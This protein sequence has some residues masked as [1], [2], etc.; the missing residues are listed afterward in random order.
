MTSQRR[1]F[2]R[3][4]GSVTAIRTSATSSAMEPKNQTNLAASERKQADRDRQHG[5]CREV[6]EDEVPV[7]LAVERFGLGGSRGRLPVDLEVRHLGRRLVD[8]HPQ[9]E[10][11]EEAHKC[12]PDAGVADQLRSLPTKDP[13]TSSGRAVSNASGRRNI[14]HDDIAAGAGSPSVARGRAISDQF[15]LRE[16]PHAERSNP[17]RCELVSPP[18]APRTGPSASRA[19]PG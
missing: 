6:L 7:A 11:D 5:K 2:R 18:A 17:E 3:S 9:R 19:G 10:R 8:E 14:D 16:Q 12:Q 1:G 4:T 15:T 13:P